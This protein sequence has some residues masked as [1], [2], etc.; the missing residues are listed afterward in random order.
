MNKIIYPVNLQN[1]EAL[2]Q[3]MGGEI[4][5]DFTLG[6]IRNTEQRVGSNAHYNSDGVEIADEYY[7]D[8]ILTLRKN[9]YGTG[10]TIRLYQGTTD[11]GKYIRQNPYRGVSGTGAIVPGWYDTIYQEGLHGEFPALIQVSGKYFY[12]YRDSD[13]DDTLSLR[14]STIERGS[15]FQFHRRRGDR[16]LVGQASGGCQVPLVEDDFEEIMRDFRAYNR[17]PACSYFLLHSHWLNSLEAAQRD[18]VAIQQAI[19]NIS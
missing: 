2:L 5:D 15:G 9:K 8:T 12:V 19:A 4:K 10:I 1:L 18:W 6:A 3:M 7:N 11:P 14:N 17:G 16:V 13:K